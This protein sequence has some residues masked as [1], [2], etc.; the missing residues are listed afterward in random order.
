[1]WM[2]LKWMGG[3]SGRP[4][5]TR[6]PC[7]PRATR[8]AMEPQ[9]PPLRLS[10]RLCKARCGR[11]YASTSACRRRARS[12]CVEHL[13]NRRVGAGPLMCSARLWF[14]LAHQ[15][16]PRVSHSRMHR[17]RDRRYH[18]KTG[19]RTGDGPIQ[20]DRAG[21]V[22]ELDTHT[23]MQHV[24][25]LHT[26]LQ[27]YCSNTPPHPSTHRMPSPSR[28]KPRRPRPHDAREAGHSP[29]AERHR[30]LRTKS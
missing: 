1:M 15:R 20:R 6:A 27:G 8:G 30:P 5:C 23:F 11:G 17:K 9:P 24:M 13:A 28:L 25:N 26:Y 21:E 22:A 18:V 2:G 16:S 3:G 4:S 12:V 14:R 10:W 29:S 7:H 19:P